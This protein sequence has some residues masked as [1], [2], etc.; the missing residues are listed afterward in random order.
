MAYRSGTY[1]AFHAAGS[2]D[3]T[4]SDMKYYNLL[5]AWTELKDTDFSFVNS[6]EKAAAVRDSS[7]RQRLRDVLA[8]RLRNSKNMVLVLGNTTRFDADWV[9]FEISYAIDS[10][11][12]P[13]IAAYPGYEYILNPPGLAGTWPAALASRIQL[14]TAHVIHVPF[15]RSVLTAAIRQFSYNNY[16]NGNGLGWYSREAYT[17]FGIPTR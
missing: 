6:H 16:P 13:I 15:K 12:I 9:P 11:K 4:A 7:S 14:G 3:P 8:E 1:V 10:C 5:R 2:S 17:S